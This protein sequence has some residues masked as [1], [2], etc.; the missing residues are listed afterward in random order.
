MGFIQSSLKAG[1]YVFTLLTVLF[2]V[3]ALYFWSVALTAS[4][5]YAMAHAMAWTVVVGVG[6]AAVVSIEFVEKKV[7][8]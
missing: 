3:A 1:R 2:L 8:A 4:A 7:G 5:P 6:V